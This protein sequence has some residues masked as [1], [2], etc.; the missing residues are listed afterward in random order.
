MTKLTN[1]INSVLRR[2][3]IRSYN[4]P[5]AKLLNVV[6][7]YCH[8]NKRKITIKE[9]CTLLNMQQPNVSRTVI[10]LENKG[11]LVTDKENVK[12]KRPKTI[13]VY[14]NKKQLP[15]T[16][17]NN[18]IDELQIKLDEYRKIERLLAEKFK[19][20][21]LAAEVGTEL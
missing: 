16:K 19:R 6:Q 3:K 12:G 17:L 7:I 1:D 20:D 8:Y 10:R 15:S 2:A 11:L 18:T 13:A 4:I 21:L 9:L 14:P 5:E